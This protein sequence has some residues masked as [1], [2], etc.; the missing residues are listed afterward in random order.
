MLIRKLCF[1]LAILALSLPLF[2]AIST[3]GITDVGGGLIENTAPGLKQANHASALKNIDFQNGVARTRKGYENVID[4]GTTARVSAN[5]VYRY[6][7]WWKIPA[8]GFSSSTY[9]NVHLGREST[10]PVFLVNSTL[11]NMVMGFTVPSYNYLSGTLYV[12]VTGYDRQAVNSTRNPVFVTTIMTP[13][14]VNATPPPTIVQYLNTIE[15][16][17]TASAFTV[18]L[19][20]TAGALVRLENNSN[21]GLRF[22]CQFSDITTAGVYV[23]SPVQTYNMQVTTPGIYLEVNYNI[24]TQNE[25]TILTGTSN[26]TDCFWTKFS[27]ISTA[28]YDWNFMISLL[29]TDKVPSPAEYVSAIKFS[30]YTTTNILLAQ[31]SLYVYGMQSATDKLTI[32]RNLSDFNVASLNIPTIGTD[33]IEVDV[34]IGWNT[35]DIPISWLLD[36]DKGNYGLSI[37]ANPNRADVRFYSSTAPNGPRLKIS[38]FSVI[39]N[40]IKQIYS[41]LRNDGTEYLFGTNDT[42]IYKLDS[43]NQWEDFYTG[44]TNHKQDAVAYKNFFYF[45][46]T[47]NGL[48]KTDGTNIR[49]FNHTPVNTFTVSTYNAGINRGLLVGTYNYTYSFSDTLGETATADTTQTIYIPSSSFGVIASINEVFPTTPLT[50][51]SWTIYR[52]DRQTTVTNDAILGVYYLVA[53]SVGGRVTDDYLTSEL[54]QRPPGLAPSCNIIYNWQARLWLADDA[55]HNSVLYHTPVS[56]YSHNYDGYWFSNYPLDSTNAADEK[57]IDSPGQITGIADVAGNLVIFKRNEIFAGVGSD[58]NSGW[59]VR[60]TAAKTGTNSPDTIKQNPDSTRLYYLAPDGKVYS[61]SGFSNENDNYLF[62]G[63]FSSKSPSDLI[64]KTY[65]TFNLDE[66]GKATA[67]FSEDKYL[68]SVPTGSATQNNTTIVWDDQQQNWSIWSIKARDYTEYDNDVHFVGDDSF[69]YKLSSTV[70]QDAGNPIDTEFE[71]IWLD[72]GNPFIQKEL[73][74]FIPLL[75]SSGDWSVDWFLYRDY[76]PTT[77][78][79]GSISLSGAD[80]RGILID[81]I[82]RE[83]G[84]LQARFFKV[85]F[86]I[87]QIDKY[88][89][90]YGFGLGYENKEG[91]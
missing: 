74:H 76:S 21:Y 6:D 34:S 65:N 1:C 23:F 10:D 55:S 75:E 51:N 90:I 50:A 9:N 57:L 33:K 66:L 47:T 12:P 80:S 24:N 17:T 4:E 25:T 56:D 11:N 88:M 30:N 81:C 41:F 35:I 13:V 40:K 2:G 85:K 79:S 42:A 3:Y 91:Y 46:S 14:S 38:Y 78:V 27:G 15:I 70:Y 37:Y 86:K 28:V 61:Y 7:R 71:T 73:D 64:D 20:V 48:I 5:E 68:C 39:S 43:T 58:A 16:T 26:I 59:I 32:Y 62:L 67:W 72:M 29:W 18:E 60:K 63:N 19:P 84:G 52:T 87:N 77:N 54:G 89:K 69:V 45:T 53:N 82:N 31:M 83:V 44:I 49:A 22:N 36:W 8:N